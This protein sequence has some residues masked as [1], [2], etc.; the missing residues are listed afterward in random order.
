MMIKNLTRNGES[1]L[2]TKVERH[3]ACLYY[4]MNKI[5]KNISMVLLI[6]LSPATQQLTFSLKLLNLANR[7]MLIEGK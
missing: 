4:H 2:A 5:Y 6:R 7:Y 1:G 3:A